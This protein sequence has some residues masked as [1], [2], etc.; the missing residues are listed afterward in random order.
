[1]RALAGLKRGLGLHK[2]VTYVIGENGTGKSTIIEGI[3]AGAGFREQGGSKFLGTDT[4]DW[5]PLTPA[6]SLT[7]A[8]VQGVTLT[9]MP[10]ARM[11]SAYDS[12]HRAGRRERRAA[13]GW[14]DLRASP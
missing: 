12:S 5:S 10:S 3:A 7:P 1:M 8:A 14:C 11:R 2:K 9:S 4:L 13:S 6:L